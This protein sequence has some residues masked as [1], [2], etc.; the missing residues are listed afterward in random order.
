MALVFFMT[1]GIKLYRPNMQALKPTYSSPGEQG[2]ESVRAFAGHLQHLDLVDKGK[3]RIT[4]DSVKVLFFFH[5]IKW[6]LI[7]V[8]KM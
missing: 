5:C 2:E 3:G 7:L 1:T 6:C 4:Q 8:D